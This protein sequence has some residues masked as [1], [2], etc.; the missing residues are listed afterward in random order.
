MS[1]TD[2][3]HYVE[4]AIDYGPGALRIAPGGSLRKTCLVT[5]GT[6]PFD[7]LVLEAGAV[8]DLCLFL[9]PEAGISVPLTVHLAGEGAD[10]RLSAVCLC[11]GEETIFLRTKVIHRAGGCTST[12]VVNGLAGGASR[13]KFHGKIVV[14]PGAVKTEA[15]QLNRNLL[16]SETARVETLPQLEIYAD[17][18]KCD[19]GAT[20]G[21]L[22]EDE[23]FY[24]RSRGI[25]EK[26]AGV[27]LALSFLAPV[28]EHVASEAERKRLRKTVEAEI[29]RLMQWC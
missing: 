14:A 16:L 12:Q 5:A 29:R 27:L 6:L 20:I 24:L 3:G 26:E 18:V 21:S 9:F 15:H 10:F 28:W 23:R 4:E 25:P 13:I 22:N 7:R 8:A 1:Y 17:D 11:G 2:Q 19:H